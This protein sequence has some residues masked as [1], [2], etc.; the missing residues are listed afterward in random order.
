MN[1]PDFASGLKINIKPGRAFGK[2]SWK[3]TCYNVASL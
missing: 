3:V 1:Q 2:K